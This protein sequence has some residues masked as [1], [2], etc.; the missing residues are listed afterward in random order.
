MI[1]KARLT[2]KCRG[3][4]IPLTPGQADLLDEY[5]RILVE[6]N[7]KVNLTAITDPAGI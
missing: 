6:Y 5:A 4:G 1:D 7:E 2:E 3:L